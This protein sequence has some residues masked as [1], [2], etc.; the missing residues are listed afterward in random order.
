MK[1]KLSHLIALIGLALSA[2]PAAAQIT[3]VND[4]NTTFTNVVPDAATPS[5]PAPGQYNLEAN[6]WTVSFDAGATADKLIVALSSE[7]GSGGPPVITYNGVALTQVPNTINSRVKGIWY[8]DNP[9][10]TVILFV[11]VDCMWL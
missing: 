11:T 7:T 6:P 5:F 10:T 4:D 3:I 2:L 8:L 9:Y 1:T